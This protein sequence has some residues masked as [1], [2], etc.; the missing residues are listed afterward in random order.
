M[1]SQQEYVAQLAYH[2]LSG[3]YKCD[4]DGVWYEKINGKWYQDA[5]ANHFKQAIASKVGQLYELAAA[6]RQN[7]HDTFNTA[8]YYEF[9]DVAAHLQQYDIPYLNQVVNECY[10][11]YITGHKNLTK[12]DTLIVA[13]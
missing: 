13:A 2:N 9:K 3:S 6:Q 4:P 5:D 10:K 12:G 8:A 1:K 11:L 7:Y